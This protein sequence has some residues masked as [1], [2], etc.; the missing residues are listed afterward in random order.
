MK[1][2]LCACASSLPSTTETK[3]HAFNLVPRIVRPGNINTVVIALGL[4]NFP[5]TCRIPSRVRVR[6]AALT[7]VDQRDRQ[8]TEKREMR[9]NQNIPIS[10]LVHHIG[11]ESK[12][13]YIQGKKKNI[14]KHST[15]LSNSCAA[16]ALILYNQGRD[17]PPPILA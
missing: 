2:L 14:A 9:E 13:F 3:S 15:K 6:I 10:V 11:A 17:T 4:I 7:M 16:A 1:P 5:H 12:T 8:S